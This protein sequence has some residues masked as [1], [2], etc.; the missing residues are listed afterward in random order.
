MPKPGRL[1]ASSNYMFPG[2]PPETESV[3]WG[4]A[5]KFIFGFNAGICR[6]P[7]RTFVYLL[8]NKETRGKS[9]KTPILYQTTILL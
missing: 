6:A 3:G 4:K 1:S 5:W 9:L 8:L 7:L 2:L